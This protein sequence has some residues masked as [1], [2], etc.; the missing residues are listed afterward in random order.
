ARCFARQ[1]IQFLMTASEREHCRTATRCA[2]DDRAAD[3]AGGAGH[4]PGLAREVGTQPLPDHGT[5]AIAER[6]K[7]DEE[8]A[9]K[10]DRLLEP[11]KIHGIP[12]GGARRGCRSGSVRL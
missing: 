10:T 11:G 5:G 1:R 6:R 2:L 3:A 8:S 7:T 9:V 12:C 4:D